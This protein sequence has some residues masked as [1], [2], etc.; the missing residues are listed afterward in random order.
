M[1]KGDWWVFLGIGIIIICSF[2]GLKIYKLKNKSVDQV[3]IIKQN[4]KII[5]VIELSSVKEPVIIEI[6][7]ENKKYNKIEIQSG[8]IRFIESS[9][10]DQVCVHTGWINEAGSIAVC[11]PNMI[12][13]E[14]IQAQQ[15]KEV[16]DVVY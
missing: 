10:P 2:I 8:R 3:A 14:I 11:L 4:N 13:I 7:D 12:S 16:D 6:K 15:T 5:D 1:K 9:C